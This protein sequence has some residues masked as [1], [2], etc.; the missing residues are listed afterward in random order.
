MPILKA[1]RGGQKGDLSHFI[2]EAVRP[3]IPAL[4]VE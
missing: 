4:K 1:E 2:Q 3:H